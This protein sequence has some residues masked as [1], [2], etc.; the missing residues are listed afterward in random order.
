MTDIIA[1]IVEHKAEISRHLGEAD[2]LLDGYRA[3]KG[4]TV[5]EMIMREYSA[6]AEHNQIITYLLLQLGSGRVSLRSFRELFM[7]LFIQKPRGYGL[8]IFLVKEKKRKDT[9]HV[10]TS[11]ARVLC[12]VTVNL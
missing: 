12:F 11:C 7:C 4:V 3:T 10:S 9:N 8:N 1:K 2:K 6:I 5:E